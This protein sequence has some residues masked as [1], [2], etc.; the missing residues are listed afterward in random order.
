MKGLNPLENKLMQ[1]RNEPI[2]MNVVDIAQL[3]DETNQ[4][5]MLIIFRILPKDNS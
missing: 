3:L 4:E 2:D 5:K 1:A